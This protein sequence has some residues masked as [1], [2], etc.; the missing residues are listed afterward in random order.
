M[1]KNINACFLF[2]FSIAAWILAHASLTLINAA[3]F[4]DTSSSDALNFELIIS[5]ILLCLGM[6]VFT[7]A[8]VSAFA[9][10]LGFSR[11]FLAGFQFLAFPLGTQALKELLFFI[12]LPGVDLSLAF[13][14]SA[15]VGLASYMG[16]FVINAGSKTRYMYP[17]SSFIEDA[18]RCKG[19]GT[20]V[21]GVDRKRF[22]KDVVAVEDKERALHCQVVGS[23]G[24][25]KTQFTLSLAFQDMLRG[26]PVFFME[27]KAD[28]RDFKMFLDLAK[29]AGR[30]K[31]V[32]KIDFSD[33][34]SARINPIRLPG[35][36]HDPLAIANQ[37]ILA[38]GREPKVASESEFYQSL[39]LSRVFDMARIFTGMD[40]CLSLRRTY[41]YFSD[42]K[43]REKTFELCK[44]IKL[45]Q[46][47]KERLA[48]EAGD[49]TSLLTHL[50]PWSMGTL[51]RVLNAKHPD[52]TIENIFEKNLLAYVL[53]P[54]GSLRIQ[55][56]ALGKMLIELLLSYSQMR[57]KKGYQT[58]ASIILEEFSEFVTP[59]FSA[60]VTT[61]RSA[62]LC[63]TLSH[64]DF[65]QLRKVEGT[66]KDAF[67]G[68]VIGN[69][70][71]IKV[72]FNAV[73]DI[74]AEKMAKMFGTFSEPSRTKR[75]TAGAMG[76]QSVGDYSERDVE[77]FH[78]HPN[79]FKRLVPF[80]AGVRTVGDNAPR[81]VTTPS[82]FQIAL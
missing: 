25:G 14:C 39:D 9:L 5:G 65:S 70:A 13:P 72:F 37:I 24:S 55:T 21:L 69:T 77:S 79:E 52:V 20:F 75:V 30:E 45:V 27:N 8:K 57:Q 29:M 22:L 54:L 12:D 81:L 66:D 34:L 46:G 82:V 42:R 74:N 3:I 26:W 15:G 2:V 47:A 10:S 59:S 50:A 48:A 17:A 58:P 41:M 73:D 80:K 35:N 11:M 1:S 16:F 61:A 60:L 53:I 23:S 36:T 76:M 6:F 38:I 67:I 40:Q 44:K 4:A 7:N 33:P 63:L 71:G 43:Y 49:F 19:K 78:I 51:G 62:G 28:S 68:D 32:I 31:D 64:Q 56:N 18:K